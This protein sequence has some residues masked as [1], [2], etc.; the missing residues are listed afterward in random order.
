MGN[1]LCASEASRYV[2]TYVTGV[3]RRP[4]YPAADMLS[5]SVNA[6]GI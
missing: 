5:Y 6:A 1:H 2:V 4:C 3:I